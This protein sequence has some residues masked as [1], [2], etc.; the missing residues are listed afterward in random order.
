MHHGT[1]KEEM[2]HRPLIHSRQAWKF[3]EVGWESGDYQTPQ[4]AKA[5]EQAPTSCPVGRQSKLAAASLVAE[6]RGDTT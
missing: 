5:E 4:Q 2:T 6:L 3:P 1:E